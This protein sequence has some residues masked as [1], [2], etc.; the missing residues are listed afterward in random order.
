L[1]EEDM[2]AVDSDEALISRS[3]AARLL[4][5]SPATLTRLMARGAIEFYKNGW[6]TQFDLKQI[7]D[8]KDSVRTRRGV[9]AEDDEKASAA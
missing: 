6:R 1:K 9:Q 7:R 8:Y 5:V 4:G 2:G 3:E